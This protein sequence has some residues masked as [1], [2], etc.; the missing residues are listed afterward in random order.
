M[1]Q[2]KNAILGGTF[3][4]FHLGHQKLIDTAFEKSELVTIG[5]ATSELFQHKVL[6]NSIENYDEREAKLK[7]YLTEKG[8]LDNAK[9]I[10]ISDIFGTTLTESN[11]DAIF[12]TEENLKNVNLINQKRHAINFPELIVEIVPYVKDEQG[13]NITSERI[14]KG[15][16]DS[17]GLI[18]KNIFNK[19]I[20]KLP[21]N[22][23]EELHQPIGQVVKNTEEVLA[24][25]KEKTLVIAVGDVIVNELKNKNEAPDIS[26]IDFKTRRQEMDIDANILGLKVINE[27]GTISREAVRVFLKAL[28][29]YFQAGEKQMIIVEG[30]EDLLALPAILL[31]PLG[32]VVL[33][34]QF[35]QGVVVNKV[36]EAKKAKILSLLQRFQ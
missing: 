7:K 18:Y 24:Y 35:D 1:K 3:D 32:A 17:N 30:E 13:E 26:I 19:E 27:Q 29:L 2:Y 11:I 10:P 34:G 21:E 12:A 8:Y 14:R 22:L 28:D 6:N 20:L 25:L 15:E 9:I 36:D 33:Y 4:H 5:L 16:I 31:S 23:R